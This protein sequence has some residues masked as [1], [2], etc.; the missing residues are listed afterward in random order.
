MSVLPQVENVRGSVFYPLLNSTENISVQIF[1]RAPVP[2]PT[3]Y[4]ISLMCVNSA[5]GMLE[6]IS[7]S[8]CIIAG[9]LKI[10]CWLLNFDQSTK[11]L[12]FS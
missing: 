9:K 10:F 1:W 7:V 2:R 8:T 5:T 11:I 3:A 12:S 6:Y 4:N